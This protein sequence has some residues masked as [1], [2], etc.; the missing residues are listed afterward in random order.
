M[1]EE[2]GIHTGFPCSEC[3]AQLSFTPGQNHLSCPY[4]GHEQEVQTTQ[5][6]IKEYDF[7]EALRNPQLVRANEVIA[8]AKELECKN[9]GAMTIMSGQ[10]GSCPFCDSPMVV[11]ENNEGL[12]LPESLLPFKIDKPTAQEKFSSWIKSRWFAPNDLVQKAEKEGMDGVYLPY[13]TYDSH[14]RTQYSGERGEH[15]YVEEEYTDS[16][17][18]TK[19]RRERKTRW[20][21][22]EGSVHRNFDDVMICASQSLPQ[23]LYDGLEP[24]PLQ[25]LTPYNEGYLAGFIAEKYRIPLK[26]GFQLAEQKMDVVIRSDI[27]R[28]IG[29]DEQRIHRVNTQHND[30]KY[31]LVLLPLWISSFRYNNTVYRFLV[32]A[33]TGEANGERPYSIIKIV[34]L[35][36]FIIGMIALIANMGG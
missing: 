31:K 14:T 35:I 20:Y 34:L 6:E 25:D 22:A 27:K 33:Q 19:T 5:T 16:D 32:N 10:A 36:L 23:K 17:G 4:C 7:L 26:D 28:D 1:S 24:W 11:Q 18:K 15:Y 2:K 13:W 30:I 9:C 12:I 3:G 29:G 21:H 8:A